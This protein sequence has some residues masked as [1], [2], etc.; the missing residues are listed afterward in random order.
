MF[1]Q[2]LT[3]TQAKV[4]LPNTTAPDFCL[5]DAISGKT[6]CLSNYSNK[7]VLLDFM[8]TWCSWCLKETDDV[9]VPL[10]N[11]YYA[12]DSKVV[13]LSIDIGDSTAQH[14]QAYAEQ[15]NIN[16]SILMRGRTSGVAEDYGVEGIPTTVIMLCKGTE[17]TV[18][19]TQVGYSPDN[20]NTFHEWIE[21]AMKLIPSGDLNHDS[22]LTPADAAI[23]LRIAASGG[24]D[25][26][27]DVSGDGSVTSLDALM[28]LQAAAGVINL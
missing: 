27:A 5:E 4:I 14:L 25:L 10:H 23:A 7:V 15:H 26:D 21:E 22:I 11:Q 19:N 17:R 2:A 13:F 28:I 6:I 12:N 18:Y 24:W 20:L 3:S 8:T 9:L 16:F 1:R